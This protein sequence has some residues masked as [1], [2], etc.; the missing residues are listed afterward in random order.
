[1]SN[2][3]PEG[4]S[5]FDDEIDDGAV[6]GEQLG[7]KSVNALKGIALRHWNNNGGVL[8]IG[9][10]TKP[11]SIYKNPELYPQIF[12]WLFPYGLGGIGVGKLSD[13]AHKRHLLMYHDKRFQKDVNFPFINTSSTGSFLMTEKSQFHDISERLLSLDQEKLSEGNEEKKC[14]QVIRDLDQMSGRLWSL[15]AYLGAPLWHPICLYFADTKE[16][17]EPQIRT[18]DDRFRLIASNPAFIKHVLGIFGDT[19]AYYGTVEQQGRLTL[20]LHL[21]LWIK[22][23]L[24]PDEIKRRIMDPESDFQ[25]QLVQYLESA[26]Q[27]EFT[28]GSHADVHANVSVAEEKDDYADPTETL[29]TPPPTPCG[30]NC[31]SCKWCTALKSWTERYLF[32]SDDIVLKTNRRNWVGCLDN[33]WGKCKARFP[34]LLFKTTEVDPATGNLNI[35]KGEPW[36][37]T[38]SPLI[39]YLFR[40]NTDVTSLRSGTA[41]K[42]VLLYVS[43]YTHMIFD[44]IRSMFQ[45]NTE[46]IGGTKSQH[47]KARSL[48]TKIVNTLSAKME[49]GAPMVCIHSFQSFYW[50]A[51]VSEARRVWGEDTTGEAPENIIIIKRRGRV[52]GLSHVYDYTFRPLSLEN[53]SLYEFISRCTREKGLP[54]TNQPKEKYLPEIP[55]ECAQFMNQSSQELLPPVPSEQNDVSLDE[56]RNKGS[57]LLFLLNGHPLSDSHSIRCAPV[58]KALVPNFI[59]PTL[60]R[61]D[62]GDREYYCLTIS[63]LDLKP[64]ESSWD[65]EFLRY[66]FTCHHKSL[67]RNFNLRYECLDARDDF[68]AQMRKGAITMPAWAGE[69]GIFKELDQSIDVLM[70]DQEEDTIIGNVEISSDTGRSH[71]LRQMNINLMSDVMKRLGWTDSAPHLLP[72]SLDLNPTP[73]EITQS[74]SQWKAVVALKRAEILEERS[75]NNLENLDSKHNKHFEVSNDV[76]VVNKSHLQHNFKSESWKVTIDTI[77]QDFRLNKE[78][79]RAY[80]IVAHHACDPTADQLKMY[81]GGMGGTGKTQV[82]K[83]L[84]ELHP[85][86]LGGSTYHYMFGIND[87]S[88][89]FSNVKMAQVKSRLI[90]VDYV[91]LDEV[92]MLSCRDLYTIGVRLA[93]SSYTYIKLYTRAF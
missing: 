28:T 34:R 73:P 38:F 64:T 49:M 54:K 86:L 68:H 21:L 63:G 48:M 83:A 79:E 14:Y 9:R 57:T 32:E 85:A 2:K 67:M 50:K 11:E 44:T 33:V 51:Y 3:V 89:G 37:N 4:T 56:L 25:R 17:F 47:E 93:F 90:G 43:N 75:K 24:S 42:G 39:S 16:T 40:C 80:H 77:A 59:G 23:C 13:T 8:S 62:S 66:S 41:I 74:G 35:K 19:S 1:M 69:P 29:P 26:H 60:P 53:M 70:N 45:K 78:Q 6:D 76:K 55:L 65:E 22:G 31:G 27:G 71:N 30:A 52:V 81:I 15:M 87:T 88:T 82:L 92:S 10:Q 36:I 58:T 84:G 5:V 61:C 18:S 46:M 91:F 7:S 20:H 72:D 12:P